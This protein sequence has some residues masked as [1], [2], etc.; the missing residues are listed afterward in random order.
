MTTMSDNTDKSDTIDHE[1]PLPAADQV[2]AGAAKAALATDARGMYESNMAALPAFVGPF[3]NFGFWPRQVGRVRPPTLAD[4]EASGLA[5]YERVFDALDPRGAVAEVGCGLAAGCRALASYYPSN[6]VASITGVDASAQQLER[7]SVAM[8]EGVR[9]RRLHLIK[10]SAERLPFA[11]G[12]LDR[13]YTV[14]ALQHFGCASTFVAEAA[15]CLAP[16]GRLVV[17]TFLASRVLAPSEHEAI[18]SRIRTVAVGIDKLVQTEALCAAMADAGL[19][20]DT[21]QPIGDRVWEAFCAWC[22]MAQPSWMWPAAW[23]DAYRAGWVDYYVLTADKP[24]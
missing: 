15:R 14:E 9:D 7:A 13:I 8:A 6:V 4:R 22:A 1:A 17:C 10:A 2:P 5:L 23:L 19:V 11:D 3:I 18:A 20:V 21:P 24:L 12:A 16:G